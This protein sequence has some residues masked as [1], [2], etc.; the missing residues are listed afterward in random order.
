[1]K[2]QK[3]DVPVWNSKGYLP[4]EEVNHPSGKRLSKGPV[5]VIECPQR[6]PC[7]PCEEN[8]PVG[9]IHMEDINGIPTVDTEKCTGCSI[10]LENCPGLAI[11]T[12]DCSMEGGCEVTLPYE[13]DLPEVGE[14]VIALNRKGEKVITTGVKEIKTKDN[15]SGDTSTVTIEISEKY[16]KEVRNIRRVK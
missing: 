15:S 1:M 12:L 7:D 11:F 3:E 14:E 9:A 2:S 4:S 6:I 5:A 13:F 8:C 16:V 10:C